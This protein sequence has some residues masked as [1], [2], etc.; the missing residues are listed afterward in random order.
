M[1]FSDY[2]LDKQKK[3][4]EELRQMLVNKRD[5]INGLLAKA[6]SLKPQLAEIQ[7]ALMVENR[8]LDRMVGSPVPDNKERE[9]VAEE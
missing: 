5:E 4:C 2:E 7:V 6:E 1:L 3:H 8:L 9:D